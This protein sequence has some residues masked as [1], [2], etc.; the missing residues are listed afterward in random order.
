MTAVSGIFKNGT[1]KLDNVYVSEKP[2]KVI[3]TFLEEGMDVKQKLGA[4]EEEKEHKPKTDEEFLAFLLGGPVMT[5]EEETNFNETRKA[6]K[7]WR[8]K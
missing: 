1:I 8:T 7:K 5:K 3:V 2:V 6:F 4:L